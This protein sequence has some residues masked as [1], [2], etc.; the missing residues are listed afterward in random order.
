M[1]TNV[2]VERGATEHNT[3][4]LRRFTRRVQGSGILRRVRGIRFYDRNQSDFTKRKNALKKIRKKETIE[5][6]LKMGAPVEQLK[7]RR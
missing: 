2:Q 4:I 7:R 1:A 5:H 6:L 3:S